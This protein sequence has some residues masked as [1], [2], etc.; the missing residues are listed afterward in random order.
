[1]ELI[2]RVSLVV[3]IGSILF[4]LF[5]G[6]YALSVR[7]FLTNFDGNRE[8]ENLRSENMALRGELE[9]LISLAPRGAIS[10]GV[11]VRAVV[12]ASSSVRPIPDIVVS[13]GSSDGIN[14]GM[15]VLSG[16]LLVGIVRTTNAHTSIVQT[17]FD[18]RFEI[19][20]R[21]GD[22]AVDALFRGGPVPMVALIPRD[23]DISPGSAVYSASQ[24][25]PF[26]LVLGEIGEVK[27]G[28]ADAWSTAK[29]NT[30]HRPEHL[31]EAEILTSIPVHSELP[32]ET[33]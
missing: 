11:S 5:G 24:D 10:D 14:P 2:K 16:K 13:A 7:N 23:A 3:F 28:E 27:Q 18:P 31:H 15:A 20:V 25:L 6:K 32:S 33:Y 17:I 19:A 12:Y 21:V 4:F 22:K 29:L 30:P 9:K 1:M 26:G 8:L